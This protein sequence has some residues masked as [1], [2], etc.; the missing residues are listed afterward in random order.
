MAY[1]KIKHG[2]S[3]LISN[4]GGV[5]S[6]IETQECS[7]IIETFDNWQYKNLG[8]RLSPYIIKDDRLLSRLQN[9][10]PKLRHIVQIPTKNNTAADE[11]R[12]SANYFPKWFYCPKCSYFAQY[13]EWKKRWGGNNDFNTPKCW[14]PD[15]KAEILE[16]VRFVMTCKNG[17]IHDIPWK[18][19]N[20]RLST[21]QTH[22]EDENE[23][24]NKFEK[25]I[26]PQLDFTRTCCDNQKLH[27]QISKENTE[28]SGIWII[29]KNCKNRQSLKGIFNLELNCDGKK[30]WLG[31][32]DEK[33]TNENC[34]EKT[35]VKVKTSNSIYYSNSLSSIYIPE[36]QH[37]LTNEVRLEIDRMLD[38]GFD[39]EKI[40]LTIHISKEISIDIVKNYLNTGKTSYIPDN[41]YREAEFNYF[42]K[43][44]QPENNQLKFRL[45]NCRNVIH[46]FG[47]I[48]K[49]DKLKK[50]TVQT[51]FTRQEP[52]DIDSIL[53]DE[54]SYE[55][56]VKR[57]SVSK[58]DFETKLLP[59]VESYGEGILF[60]LDEEKLN[61]WEQNKIVIDR[62]NTILTKAKHSTSLYHQI[63][64][65]TLT[66]RKILV[67]T[68][69]HILIRE[70]EYVCGYPAASLQERLYVSDN[71]YG[72]LISAF[73]GTD[74]YLGG[75]AN[76]CENL[77]NLNSIIQSAIQRAS[78]C[79][80]DPICI[81]SEGQGVSQLNLAAC[82]SCTLTPEI[83]CEL[84]NLFL[85]RKSIID[86]H[87][88]YF[89]SAY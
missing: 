18:H 73:D 15:C 25:P 85:D 62:V 40:A 55:Y 42:L 17:H 81:E 86:K 78:D 89:T 64:A 22:L 26:G 38:H 45:F 1:N 60:V 68:L 70:L 43:G 33:W 66:P 51:S 32:F 9:R 69:S 28:L 88:G 49:I 19:W 50:I 47:K 20:M 21:D 41:V 29:C 44:E 12:P 79:S 83:T 7:I 87:F 37:Q 11:I 52:I 76:L 63:I 75:L 34:E 14:N 30:Y 84:S 59:G 16:Q 65:K 8:N 35:Q 74:G 2:R 61:R 36:M 23:E 80:S 39:K 31:F 82:H 10:F 77:D 67:H 57:Q 4:Y 54:K 48:V 24:T 13:N 6:L 56:N 27:Y 3:K 58:N 46:G 53:Q 5:A 71:M 72:V